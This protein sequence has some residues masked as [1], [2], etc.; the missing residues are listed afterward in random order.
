M[1]LQACC[2]GDGQRNAVFTMAGGN[3]A[4]NIT[5]N[6]LNASRNSYQ[7][8][9]IL[10]DTGSDITLI[11]REDGERLGFSPTKSGNKFGVGGV[12]AGAVEFAKFSTMIRIENLAPVQIDFGV[13]E[14]YGALRDNL[15]GREDIL[16]QYNI[17]FSRGSVT[18]S[19]RGQR[20]SQAM[21]C[22]MCNR[23]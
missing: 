11:S 21:E 22:G 3:S 16:D 14:K 18:F 20:A 2:V 17:T 13:A 1:A 8:V 19:P 12:G 23:W 4:H 7:P 6:F 10:A 15:L 9:R 5:V